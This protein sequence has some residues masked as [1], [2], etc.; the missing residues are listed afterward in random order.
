MLG[1]LQVNIHGI[2]LPR[3]EPIEEVDEGGSE[4][5]QS[6]NLESGQSKKSEKSQ[7]ED[8]LKP[9]PEES[10]EEKLQQNLVEKEKEEPDYH[11]DKVCTMKPLYNDYLSIV[12]GQWNFVIMVKSSNEEP[13]FTKSLELSQLQSLEWLP[14]K[15]R[16]TVGVYIHIVQNWNR[17]LIFYV[18]N[19]WEMS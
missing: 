4:S 5:G 15:K 16:C 13:L 14:T 17:L 2:A 19:F 9:K 1:I 10:L 7:E 6:K 11:D 18:S 3:V 12:A 8:N